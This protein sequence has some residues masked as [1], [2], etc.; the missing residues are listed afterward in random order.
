MLQTNSRILQLVLLKTKRFSTFLKGKNLFVHRCL[1]SHMYGAYLLASWVNANYTRGSYLHTLLVL[2]DHSFPSPTKR[3]LRKQSSLGGRETKILF[4]VPLNQTPA[5]TKVF[6]VVYTLV[7]QKG[8]PRNAMNLPIISLL[9]RELGV[10]I[11]ALGTKCRAAERQFDDGIDENYVL[12]NAPH[13]LCYW[14]TLLDSNVSLAAGPT[15][16]HGGQSHM[17]TR[18]LSPCCELCAVV[19]GLHLWFPKT[20]LGGRCILP[21]FTG[22]ET[23]LC[24]PPHITPEM[25]WETGIWSVR[26]RIRNTEI[27]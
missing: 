17:H 24:E 22:Q 21:H 1:P 10:S 4:A 27:L 8:V 7:T 23:M 9:L 11:L 6:T 5:G 26:F 3:Q 25:F 15:W 2:S 16:L 14:K 12:K 18:V 19:N 13:P 20:A